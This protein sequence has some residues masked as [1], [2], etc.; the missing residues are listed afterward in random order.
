VHVTI[1]YQSVVGHTRADELDVLA[2]V[3]AVEAAL[4]NIGARTSRL[5]CT[6]DLSAAARALASSKPDVVFNLVE[7]LDGHGELIAA[8]PGLLDALNIPYTGA[9]AEA[10]YLTT[11][12][13]LARQRLSAVGVPIAA[14]IS[15]ATA[16]KFIVKSVW[17]HA[18][19]GLDSGSVVPFEDVEVEILSR[20]QQFGGRFFAEAYIDG[21]EFNV[22]ILGGPGEPEV[23]PVAEMVFD[24]YP[25]DLPRVVDY[26][27]KWDPSSFGY[28]HT[29][30]RFLNAA[31]EW[32]LNDRLRQL[33]V[34][35][36]HAFELEGY[37]RVDF[38]VDG[39]KIVVVDINANPCLSPDA[40]YVAAL[41]E[42]RI[43]FEHAIERIVQAA[44]VRQP[45]RF[46]GFTE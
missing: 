15:E 46:S 22:A 29:V 3:E 41:K 33:S 24:G 4:G 43:L 37:A 39:E 17:E 11:N 34:E 13:P 8:F 20:E 2:Q 14:G 26:A 44:I 30:R 19:R 21:R 6:L 42:G 23:L 36:W 28:R 45:S 25:S 7:S 5:A 38:R 12:K 35:C 31:S 10:L 1:C 32:K 9:S 27:A 40:G 16:G 18:S